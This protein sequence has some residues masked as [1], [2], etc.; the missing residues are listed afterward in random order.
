MKHL[1][2]FLYIFLH[3]VYIFACLVTLYLSVAS[4]ADL[5][6]V[7]SFSIFTRVLSSR[8]PPSP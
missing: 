6:R 7:K 3:I 5:G 4:L 1:C 8:P 2:I